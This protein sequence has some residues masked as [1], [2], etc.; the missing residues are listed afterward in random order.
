MRPSRA[1]RWQGPRGPS[2]ERTL[3]IARRIPSHPGREKKLDAVAYGQR[4][5]RGGVARTLRY[6]GRGSERV[7]RG[8]QGRGMLSGRA[9]TWASEGSAAPALGGRGLPSPSSRDRS[10]RGGPDPEPGRHPCHRRC[11]GSLPPWARGSHQGAASR[12]RGRPTRGLRLGVEL[13]ERDVFVCQIRV[14]FQDLL[15]GSSTKNHSPDMTDSEAALGEH[16]LATEDVGRGHELLLPSL[17]AVELALYPGARL[18]HHGTVT[19]APAVWGASKRSTL[20]LL[21]G[22]SDGVAST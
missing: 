16:G 4:R 15:Q 22:F 14:V 10:P 6:G 11:G 19:I 12:S 9:S 21:W 20:A 7:R 18:F 2:P 1:S 13:G 17:E 5:G 8:R 3:A